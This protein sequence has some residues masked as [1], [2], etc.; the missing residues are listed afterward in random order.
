[1][2]HGKCESGVQLIAYCSVTDIRSDAEYQH[3]QA[4]VYGKKKSAICLMTMAT[5]PIDPTAL[6]TRLLIGRIH[7]DTIY[8]RATGHA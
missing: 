1:M 6:K 7:G 8:Y 2:K 4:F 3:I 5:E